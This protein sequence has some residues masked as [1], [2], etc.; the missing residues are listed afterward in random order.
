MALEDVYNMD[1]IGSFILCPKE[2]NIV[3]QRIVRGLKIQKECLSLA[4]V[5]NTTYIDKLKHV[6]ID[7]SLC[8]SG[9]P[10]N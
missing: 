10:T 4:L 5:V 7:K 9:L 6:S 2:D 1:E 8:L 3:V